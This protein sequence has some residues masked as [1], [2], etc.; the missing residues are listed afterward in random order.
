MSL[1][2]KGRFYAKLAIKYLMESFYA[3]AVGVKCIMNSPLVTYIKGTF[4][5]NQLKG[6]K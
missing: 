2:L 6:L 4:Y 5:A 1:Y 3:T